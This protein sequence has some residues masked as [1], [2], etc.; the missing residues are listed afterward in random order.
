MERGR[1]KCHQYWEG[2]AGGEGTYG[3]FTVKTIAVEAEPDYTVTTVSLV[4]NKVRAVVSRWR[5]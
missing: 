5:T 2:D 4:N 1:P 3:Q